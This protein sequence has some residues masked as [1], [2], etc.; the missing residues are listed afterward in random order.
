MS[1]IID[2]LNQWDAEVKTPKAQS[3]PF[4]LSTPPTVS[5]SK[6]SEGNIISDSTRV[7]AP[8]LDTSLTDLQDLDDDQ[9]SGVDD[10]GSPARRPPRAEYLSQAVNSPDHTFAATD[11]AKLS[12]GYTGY[13]LINQDPQYDGIGNL[14]EPMTIV[15]L[16]G[17]MECSYVWE[18]LAEVLSEDDTGPRARILVF[19]FYGHGRYVSLPPPLSILRAP[20][21]PRLPH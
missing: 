1:D 14:I 7:L 12:R 20:P 6:K 17:L 15:C 11:T 8:G 2:A 9:S 3:N 21:P 16:H 18:D 5:R 13:R 10:G 19:D 4:D